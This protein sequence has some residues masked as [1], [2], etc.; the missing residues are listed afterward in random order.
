MQRLPTTAEGRA[1]LR[2]ALVDRYPWVADA[3]IGPRAVE[4]AECDRCGVEPRL[5][6]VCGPV[7]WQAIGRRC[8][9]ELGTSAWCEGHADEAQRCLAALAVLPGEAD[10]VARLWW[11]ASGE[12][13]P[14]DVPPALAA[15]IDLDR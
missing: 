3:D 12:V 1:Q 4:A 14:D 11:V 7:P 2:A 13:R 10:A 8:A 15:G 9:A 6:G 5:V